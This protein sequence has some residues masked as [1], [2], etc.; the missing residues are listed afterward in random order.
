ML[1]NKWWAKRRANWHEPK[2][3]ILT[4]AWREELWTTKSEDEVAFNTS[5]K[6][7]SMLNWQSKATWKTLGTCLDGSTQRTPHNSCACTDLPRP[8]S[9]SRKNESADRQSS[10]SRWGLQCVNTHMAPLLASTLVF[11]SVS[12]RRIAFTTP[13]EAINFW[14]DAALYKRDK[15]PCHN[16]RTSGS[17]AIPKADNWITVF[18]AWIFSLS[19]EVWDKSF[20][21]TAYFEAE[22]YEE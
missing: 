3:V 7:A 9:K 1:Y 8:N 10:T 22:T 15:L 17:K 2:L 19:Q 14:C 5:C 6:P 12:S 21:K 11:S 16:K 13:L 20:S 4:K 18:N